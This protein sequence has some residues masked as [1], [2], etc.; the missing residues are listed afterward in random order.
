MGEFSF[1]HCELKHVMRI[2]PK[3]NSG[4]KDL[5]IKY[6]EKDIYADNGIDFLPTEEYQIKEDE[7]IFRGIHFQDKYPQKRLIT[8]LSGAAYLTV[9]DL[10]TESPCL[11]QYETFFLQEEQPEM[12]YVPEWYG[13][14]TVS[15][16][17]DT[18]ICVMND[19]RYY[20]EYSSGIRFDDSTLKIQWPI[21]E[22]AVSEKD[23]SLMT[24]EQYIQSK[25]VE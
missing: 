16:E 2:T 5:F 9:V 22:F 3:I 24:F 25:T 4:K 23:R 12:I 18:T 13:V 1:E 8:V 6:Y 14:A 15:V 10:N 20:A 11:G 7:R 21:Q 19:G 17:K